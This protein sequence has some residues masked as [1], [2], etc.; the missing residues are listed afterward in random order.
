MQL[1]DVVSG[2]ERSRLLVLDDRIVASREDEILKSVEHDWVEL[3]P[4]LLPHQAKRF[5]DR[6]RGAVHAE[7]RE[8]VKDVRDCG[9]ASIKWDRLGIEAYWVARPVPSLVVR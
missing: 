1:G 3:T 4:P 5:V 6:H 8:R 2:I 9:D 7:C